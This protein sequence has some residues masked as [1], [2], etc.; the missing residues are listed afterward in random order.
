MSLRTSTLALIA[1]RPSFPPELLGAERR[2]LS[3]SLRTLLYAQT[4]L[5]RRTGRDRRATARFQAEIVCE[6]LKGRSKHY[7]LTYDLSTFGL[8]TQYGPQYPLG[9][10]MELLLHLP[11]DM[12]G[13][14]QLSAEVVGLH[15]QSGGMRLAFRDTPTESIR[16]MHR[17]LFSQTRTMSGEA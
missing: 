4:R 8:S 12:T 11:D 14:V 16:R 1:P 6:E 3:G 9:T 2:S 7:R 15:E 10:R 13:P 17:Y 5:N